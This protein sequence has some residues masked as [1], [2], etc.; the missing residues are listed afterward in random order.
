MKTKSFAYTLLRILSLW[1]LVKFIIINF[2]SFIVG[3]YS[4]YFETK[5]QIDFQSYTV[6]MPL[7]LFIFWSVVSWILWFKADGLSNRLVISKKTENNI[8]SFN[9]EKILNV[10]IT[11]L[12]FYFVFN[13]IPDLI[14]SSVYAYSYNSIVSDIEKNKNLIAIINPVLTL[15]IGLFCIMKTDNIKRLIKKLQN[16]GTKNAS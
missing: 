3:I 10:S 4:I 5:N 11:I 14:R 2:L 15:F 7:F 8:E 1:I 16:I 13:S 12:G 6:I 9:T